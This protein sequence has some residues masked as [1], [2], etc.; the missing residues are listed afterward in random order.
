[1]MT[2]LLWGLSQKG[3]WSNSNDWWLSKTFDQVETW[4]YLLCWCFLLYTLVICWFLLGPI[5]LN[6]QQSEVVPLDGISEQ[7]FP[8]KI[9]SYIFWARLLMSHPYLLCKET[10]QNYYKSHPKGHE[11]EAWVKKPPDILHNVKTIH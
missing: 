1:M 9:S 5:C 11:L 10:I 3:S 4:K 2:I 6:P 8:I 7:S